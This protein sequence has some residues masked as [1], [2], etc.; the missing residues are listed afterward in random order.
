MRVRYCGSEYF[1]C[2][3]VCFGSLLGIGVCVGLGGYE[4]T[5]NSIEIWINDG[6]RF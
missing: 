4:T 3:D 6:G 1:D 2:D 5:R